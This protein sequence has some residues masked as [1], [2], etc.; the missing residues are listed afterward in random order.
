MAYSSWHLKQL[1]FTGKDGKE[2]VLPFAPGLS[3]IYGAS[4]TGKSFAM[5]ALDFMLG[6]SRE[7]PPIKERDPYDKV[8]LDIKFTG[9]QQV[10][11]ER[12]I[13]GG[14]LTLHDAGQSRT[15]APRHSADNL[16]NISMYLLSKMGCI[17][18]KIAEDAAGTHA[19]L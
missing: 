13:R 11:L 19:N 17:G 7:L 14:A 4:N 3:L 10:L 8:W 2:S 9:D 1:K 6:G 12:G 5:K 16:D 18:K 15:L